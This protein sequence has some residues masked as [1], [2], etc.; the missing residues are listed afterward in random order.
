MLRPPLGPYS[1]CAFLRLPILFPPAS[2]RSREG[3]YPLDLP[4]INSTRLATP[5]TP[6]SRG[7]SGSSSAV[8]PT[9][10]LTELRIPRATSKY[11]VLPI[12]RIGIYRRICDDRLPHPP[13]SRRVDKKSRV[14][15]EES[16][17]FAI[18]K[19]QRAIST[20]R[21][22]SEGETRRI[23]NIRESRCLLA[24]EFACCILCAARDT[25][26]ACPAHRCSSFF[27]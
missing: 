8:I 2:A 15:A 17:R 12:R 7:I 18:P 13:C 3:R 26:I 25:S 22:A 24:G 6:L 9:A 23:E 19:P 5:C 1:P 4:I 14:V 10:T 16:T 20:R 11:S 21:R 27:F